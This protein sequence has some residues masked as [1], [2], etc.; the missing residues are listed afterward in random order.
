MKFISLDSF[1][2]FTFLPSLL[3]LIIQS[4]FLTGYL[5]HPR[6]L[7]KFTP[8]K[9]DQGQP[10]MELLMASQLKQVYG[11]VYIY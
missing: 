6:F 11:T 8:R 4:L 3:G 9:G 10:S 1:L 5:S 7:T 2:V